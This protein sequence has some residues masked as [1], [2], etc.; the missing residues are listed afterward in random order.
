MLSE[1]IVVQTGEQQLFDAGVTLALR[2]VSRIGEAVGAE[3][4]GHRQKLNWSGSMRIMNARGTS[5][6]SNDSAPDVHHA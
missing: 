5:V 1:E 4:I 3:R 6:N 2:H